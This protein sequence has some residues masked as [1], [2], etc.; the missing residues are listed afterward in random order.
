MTDSSPNIV[1]FEALTAPV[2]WPEVFGNDHPVALEVG[3]GKGLFLAYAATANPGRN[4][5]GLE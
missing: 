3:S 2:S 1:E 5:F 4:F